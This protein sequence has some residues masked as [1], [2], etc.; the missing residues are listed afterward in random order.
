MCSGDR[1]RCTRI[2]ELYIVDCSTMSLQQ[3]GCLLPTKFLLNTPVFNS[4]PQQIYNSVNNSPGSL[5]L[6][7]ILYRI[8]RNL[9]IHYT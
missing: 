6:C 3:N 8:M 9:H 1:Q 2:N 5:E 7:V 4:G